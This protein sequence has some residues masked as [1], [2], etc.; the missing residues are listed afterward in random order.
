MIILN[1][2]C[3]NLLCDSRDMRGLLYIRMQNRHRQKVYRQLRQ[4]ILM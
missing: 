2:L 4:L 3:Q 1:K